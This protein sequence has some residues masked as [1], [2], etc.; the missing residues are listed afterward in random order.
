EHTEDIYAGIEYAG[1][2]PEAQRV[3][4]FLSKEFPKSFEKVRFGTKQKAEDFWKTVGA[5]DVLTDVCVGVGIKPVSYSVSVRLIHSGMAY[6]I[7]NRRKS[8]TLV[9]KGNIMK[10]TEG[11][12]RDWGYQ[13]AKQYFGA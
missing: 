5:K 4:D 11:A 10:F 6:A 9:H 8:V 1:G 13:V 3:L 12:F 7:R 2:T